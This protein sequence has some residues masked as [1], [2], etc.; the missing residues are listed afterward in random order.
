MIFINLGKFGL[1]DHELSSKVGRSY[2]F[3]FPWI[4]KI[5]TRHCARLNKQT[6]KNLIFETRAK[7]VS[8]ALKLEVINHFQNLINS[9]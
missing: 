8:S 9:K 1:N 6:N 5:G 2:A 7:L 4:D 3:R